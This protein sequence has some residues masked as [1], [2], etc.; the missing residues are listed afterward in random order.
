MDVAKSITK[1]KNILH[2]LFVTKKQEAEHY[3]QE[4]D[5]DI[6]QK[7]IKEIENLLEQIREGLKDVSKESIQ[8][9]RQQRD[10]QAM[11]ADKL[12]KEAD[13]SIEEDYEMLYETDTEGN[14]VLKTDED[15]EQEREQIWN[16]FNWLVDTRTRVFN[17]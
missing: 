9:L 16:D 1:I 5:V 2:H 15:I 13:E 14:K 11:E 4:L 3:N 17:I 12:R 8:R 6:Y 10:M 7:Q